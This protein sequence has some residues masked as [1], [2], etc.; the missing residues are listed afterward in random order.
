MHDKNSDHKQWTDDN[1]FQYR[2][3]VEDDAKDPIAVRNLPTNWAGLLLVRAPVRN[4]HIEQCVSNRAMVR[5]LVPSAHTPGM[6]ISLLSSIVRD[7]LEDPY[8]EG[9]EK[10]WKSLIGASLDCGFRGILGPGARQP[11]I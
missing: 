6:S 5:D 11:V 3:A 7:G 2:A 4:G 10:E 8:G 9:G 1:P